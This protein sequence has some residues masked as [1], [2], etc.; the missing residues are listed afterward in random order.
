MSLPEV[1]ILREGQERL[2]IRNLGPF[3]GLTI[4]KIKV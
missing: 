3:R 2:N 1:L 4:E